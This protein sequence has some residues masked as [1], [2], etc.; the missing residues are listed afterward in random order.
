MVLLVMAPLLALAVQEE[1]V[2]FLVSLLHLIPVRL[3]PPAVLPTPLARQ[4]RQEPTVWPVQARVLA[5][6]RLT[7]PGQMAVLLLPQQV[8]LDRV[9][10]PILAS[11]A[12][13]AQIILEVV[14][15]V[16]ERRQVL[17]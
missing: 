4:E 5:V 2:Q 17:A 8:A 14:V 10:A 11:P 15:V 3:A 9:V 1:R 13:I 12:A 6:M 16:L 7:V